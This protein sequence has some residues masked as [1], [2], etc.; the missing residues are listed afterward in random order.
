MGTIQEL[1]L[2]LD[3]LMSFNKIDFLSVLNW[4]SISLVLICQLIFGIIYFQAKN[5]YQSKKHKR[6]F[7]LLNNYFNLFLTENTNQ[8]IKIN[9]KDYILFISFWS[10][11]FNSADIYSR[12]KLIEMAKIFKINEIC[13]KKLNSTKNIFSRIHTKEICL[14]IHTL[15]NF[16]YENKFSNLIEFEIE[17]FIKHKLDII[18]F[19]ACISLLKIDKQH[20]YPIVLQEILIRENWRNRELKYLMRFFNTHESMLII[21][22]LIENSN[23]DNEKRIIEIASRTDFFEYF[24]NYIL[25]NINK[26]SIDSIC[27]A[28]KNIND[29]DDFKLIEHLKEESNWIYRSLS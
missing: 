4:L 12:N 20:Y 27:I 9:N 7:E 16:Y 10:S 25:K 21:L 13:I 15:G 8:K 14:T 18:S 1:D 24:V 19:E 28:I 11:K 26:F 3:Y 6:Y 23:I 2:S 22:K 17:T 29:P 5:Y